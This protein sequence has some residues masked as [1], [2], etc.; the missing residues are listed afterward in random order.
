MIRSNDNRYI[1]NTYSSTYDKKNYYNNL[2]NLENIL[3]IF[4]EYKSSKTIKIT[5]VG[6]IGFEIDNADSS[7]DNTW[8][9]YDPNIKDDD[10]EDVINN[11]LIDLETITDLIS[12]NPVSVR[13]I[14][15][16]GGKFI[17]DTVVKLSES[18]NK[19]FIRINADTV[20][21]ATRKQNYFS[22][23]SLEITKIY[24]E[25]KQHYVVRK[26]PNTEIIKEIYLK[27]GTQFEFS[28]SELESGTYEVI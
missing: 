18:G 26:W 24:F 21:G 23:D 9:F 25:Y 19:Y 22:V 13:R 7:D 27:P 4:P 10:N 11:N 3:S 12:N 2:S 5:N 28:A 17:P 8:V 16:E 15:V 1:E 14:R 20:E 6:V